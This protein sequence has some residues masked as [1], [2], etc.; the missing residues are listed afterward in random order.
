MS[1]DENRYE[2]TYQVQERG[3]LLF[4]VTIILSM[5]I[6]FLVNTYFLDNS[7]PWI[8]LTAAIAGAL[9]FFLGE[10]IGDAIMFSITLCVLVFVIITVTKL[11]VI[12][13]G[14]AVS[15]ATGISTGKLVY[16]I[17]R[18]TL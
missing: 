16:G 1:N 15:L 2:N 4:I 3:R 11:S 8:L 13:K 18:E 6:A 12:I 5:V 14:L 9:G 17:W 7:S 10:N